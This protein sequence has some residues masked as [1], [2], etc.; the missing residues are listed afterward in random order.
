[1]PRCEEQYVSL[2]PAP[3]SSFVGRGLRYSDR[4]LPLRVAKKYMLPVWNSRGPPGRPP[5]FVVTVGQPSPNDSSMKLAILPPQLK[6]A[7]CQKSTLVW[8]YDHSGS[9]VSGR[10]V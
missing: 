10:P 2:V 8:S 9:C 1:M 3:R 4:S 6:V 7:E 5:V